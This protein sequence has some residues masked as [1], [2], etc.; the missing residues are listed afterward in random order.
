MTE[1]CSDGPR[2]YDPLTGR[3]LSRSQTSLYLAAAAAAKVRVMWHSQDYGAVI[4]EGAARTW[5]R[6]T[7]NRLKH[8]FIMLERVR[9]RKDGPIV[10]SDF[11]IRKD[12]LT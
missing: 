6:Q 4:I 5:R 9:F 3:Q 2:T 11:R 10:A 12:I 8:L 1:Q 7:F